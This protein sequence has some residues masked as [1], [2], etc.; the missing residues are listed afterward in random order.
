MNGLGWYERKVTFSD[1]KKTEKR[2]KKKFNG[3]KSAQKKLSCVYHQRIIIFIKDNDAENNSQ[4]DSLESYKNHNSN[5]NKMY[6][7][8]MAE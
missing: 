1:Q 5:P 6:M 7:M 8:A 2:T 3:E 4:T